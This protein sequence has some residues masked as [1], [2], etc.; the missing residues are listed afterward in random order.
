VWAE[1][2]F[3]DPIADIAVLGAPDNQDLCEQATAYEEL[4]GD[5]TPLKIGV[6]FAPNTPTPVS[7]IALN[8]QIITGTVRHLGGRLWIDETSKPIIGGMS[9]SPVLDKDGAAIGIVSQS[10]I[11]DGIDSGGMSPRLIAHLPGGLLVSLRAV[12]ALNAE[13]RFTRDQFRRTA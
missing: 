1:C 9:G 13:R 2:L 6:A 4:V 8:G 3:A 7:L 11:T 10:S 5:T 12:N